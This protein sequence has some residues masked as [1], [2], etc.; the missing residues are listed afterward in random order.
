MVWL[1][2]VFPL[3]HGCIA[4]DD[5]WRPAA[6]AQFRG[7]PAPSRPGPALQHARQRQRIAI[8]AKGCAYFVGDPVEQGDGECSPFNDQLA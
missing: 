7:D 5:Q 2:T 8:Q 3:K 1:V 4:L 6:L